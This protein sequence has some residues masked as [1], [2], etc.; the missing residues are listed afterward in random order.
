MNLIEAK[1][2]GADSIL[3]IAAIL[4]KKEIQHL[5]TLAH[6]LGLEVLL[7]IHTQEELDKYNPEIKLVGINNR[8]LNTFDVDFENSILLS[9]QLPPGTVKVSESGIDDPQVVI[10]LMGYG[11][12]G[13]LI[14]EC[15]MKT[16]D[17]GKHCFEFVKSL[18]SLMDET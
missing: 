14:G 5:T 18:K 17:P 3:L 1:S 15:F 10:D 11:Y 9:Q 6:N 7:E 8:N 16:L 12:Q 4:T 2:I 13:F